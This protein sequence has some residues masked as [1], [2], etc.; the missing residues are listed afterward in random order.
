[1]SPQEV[2]NQIHD[3]KNLV[4]IPD[5]SI[6]IFSFLIFLGV[7]VVLLIIFFIYKFIK[8]KKTNERKTWFKTLENINYQNPKEAAYTITKY[9]RLLV[10]NPRDKKL[11]NELIEELEKYKYKKTVESIDDNIKAKLST[12]MDAID[13]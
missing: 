5:N 11:C 4:L 7:I 8:N 13:V 3:I 1:M 12:L 6:F 10:T 2:A 9:T